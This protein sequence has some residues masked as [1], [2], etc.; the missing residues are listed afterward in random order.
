LFSLTLAPTLVFT[1]LVHVA[2]LP[3]VRLTVLLIPLTSVP[4]TGNVP[5]LTV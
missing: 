4:L 5:T 1:V 3:T 2:Q